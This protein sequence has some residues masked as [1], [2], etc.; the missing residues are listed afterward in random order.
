MSD[1]RGIRWRQR[2]EQYSKALAQLGEAVAVC[3]ERPLSRLEKQGAIKVF[4][5]THE[6]AWNVM[7]EFFAHQGNSSLMGSRDATREA[8]AGG[9][10]E[11]GEGW[12]AMIPSRNQ[13][14][15]TYNEQVADE[16]LA[17]V[18]NRHYPLFVAFEARMRQLAHEP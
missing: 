10:I 8:F 15:H 13:T 1:S 3:R 9:L 11:D 6:L 2:L 18:V 12:M 16:I 4:E 7:K 5:F 14:A 17:E